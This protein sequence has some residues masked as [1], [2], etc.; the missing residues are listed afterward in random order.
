MALLSGSGGSIDED[1][2]H[3][4]VLG[5]GELDFGALIR[6]D[7]TVM[8]GQAGAEPV[9]LT[10][11]LMAQRHRIG[12]L[13]VFIGATWSHCA[14]PSFA[15]CVNFR[16]YCGAGANRTLAKAGLLDVLP[17]H[18]SH[19]GELISSGQL[20]IDVLLLQV[21]PPGPDGRYSLSLA[22]DYLVPAIDSA[23]VVIAE[24]NDRAPWTY[25]ER[26]LS[27]DDIDF[28]ILTSRPP[29]ESARAEPTDA[30]RVVGRRVAELIE[31]GSTLQ[32][33]IGAIPEAV[34][35]ELTGH[36][37]LGIHTGAL[38]DGGARLIEA[39]VITNA[40]KTIDA[41]TTVAG[42]AMGGSTLHQWIHRNVAVKFRS[43][44]YTHAANVLASIDR[45]TA[46]NS[47]LEVDLTGQI[48]SEVARG[49]YVGAVGG[50]LDFLRGAHRS[51]GGLPIVAMLATAG[52]G[53]HKTSRVVASL[54]G[55]ATVPRADAGLIVTEYGVA[56]LRGL[57]L[58]ERG[59]RLIAIAA[60]EF[61]DELERHV[62][63]STMR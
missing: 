52:A 2:K 16:S 47:A 23:R 5:V 35:G 41:G 17:C 15:D 42:V 58:K 14:D 9:A 44:S 38:V 48:N 39:G 55:P 18:Y 12:R 19:L 40:R 21:A 62:Y 29:L 22:H 26:S 10:Q 13:N 33:G 6:P 51:R 7:E 59:K 11:A 32:F 31:D 4:K 37:E 24:I 50:A 63:G 56:D 1:G 49:V 27:A 53:P 30:E 36:R 57:S 20:R 43:V 54:S 34:T 25:G 28:A 61:R 46:I 3:V 8:W 45:F 60:P